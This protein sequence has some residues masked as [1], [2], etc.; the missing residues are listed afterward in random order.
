MHSHGLVSAT[1]GKIIR[2]DGER[3]S[4][5]DG[6]V[7]DVSDRRNAQSKDDE[8]AIYATEYN[9]LREPG[10]CIRYDLDTASRVAS[11]INL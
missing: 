11:T 7:S 4:I 5:Q 1:P 2:A 10:I 6:G 3:H 8:C 9:I